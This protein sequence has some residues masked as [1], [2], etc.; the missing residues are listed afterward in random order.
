MLTPVTFSNVFFSDV[1]TEI[2]TRVMKSLFWDYHTHM[3][4]KQFIH[5][6]LCDCFREVLD[7]KARC[8]KRISIYKD[9]DTVVI[10]NAV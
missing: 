4:K 7:L 2:V 5:I 8:H 10:I 9:Y 1:R 3:G 6:L